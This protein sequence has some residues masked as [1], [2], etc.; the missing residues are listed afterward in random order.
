M[1]IKTKADAGPTTFSLRREDIAQIFEEFPVVQDAYSRYVPGVRI[2][3]PFHSVGASDH[4]YG[5]V[6]ARRQAYKQISEADFW[7]RYFQSQLWE[8][9]RASER[10][11]VNDE[12]TRRKDDIFDQY[13]ED[14]DWSELVY[15]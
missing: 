12:T 7:L 11:T 15:S 9:Q 2:D 4:S 3:P 1:G 13:L 10:R 8:R 6:K 14:P 5:E